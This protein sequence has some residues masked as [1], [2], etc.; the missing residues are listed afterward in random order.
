MATGL[1]PL[2][3]F[4]EFDENADSTAGPAPSQQ[5]RMASKQFGAPETTAPRKFG[6]VVN[7]NVL[8]SSGSS[9]KLGQKPLCAPVGPVVK[10]KSSA[11]K[12]QRRERETIEFTF[13]PPKTEVV[14]DDLDENNT[15]D[16]S[17]MMGARANSKSDPSCCSSDVGRIDL[18][19]FDLGLVAL[20]DVPLNLD[21]DLDLDLDSDLNLGLALS[22]SISSSSSF[23]DFIDF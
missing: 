1:R 11:T 4:R 19:T 12:S 5:R 3:V 21:L 7:T 6:S 13:A 18:D 22:D 16:I 10:T 15:L 23:S 20:D 17:K 8:A 9:L 2:S 14:F